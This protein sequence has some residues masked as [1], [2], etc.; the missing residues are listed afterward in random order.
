MKEEIQKILKE[1]FNIDVWFSYLD[2]DCTYIYV[3]N[4]RSYLDKVLEFLKCLDITIL[5]YDINYD[6]K[7]MDKLVYSVAVEVIE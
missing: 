5:S 7:D 2:F 1:R 4:N 3:D 6:L